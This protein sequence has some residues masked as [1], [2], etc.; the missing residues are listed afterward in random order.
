MTKTNSLC[1]LKFKLFFNSYLYSIQQAF[2]HIPF[3]HLENITT[4]FLNMT[5]ITD[6]TNMPTTERSKW[7]LDPFV[8]YLELAEG[9]RDIKQ[10]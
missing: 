8:S 3:T 4:H 2:I 5:F 1:G 9:V 10:E 7:T 6:K